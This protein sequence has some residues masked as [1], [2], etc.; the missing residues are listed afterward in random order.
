MSDFPEIEYKPVEIIEPQSDALAL[1]Q[2]VY[3]HPGLPLFVR[4]RAATAA[5]PF[6]RPK[7]AVIANLGPGIAASMEA[8]LRER[9]LRVIEAK[10]MEVSPVTLPAP[11]SKDAKGFRRRI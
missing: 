6:E 4:M 5:L 10:S 11:P 2:Q 3:R 9:R 7:L 8:K 1:L